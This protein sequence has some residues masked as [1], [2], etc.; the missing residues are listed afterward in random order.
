MPSRTPYAERVSQLLGSV[1]LGLALL[2][3]VIALGLEVFALAH[4][5][6]QRPDAFAAA[7]KSTKQRWVLGLVLAVALGIISLGPGLGL[8]TIIGVVIAGVYLAD[9]KPAIEEV[10]GRSR[11]QRGGRW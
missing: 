10:L 2:L 8:L 9:V 1:Q 4:A 3:S 11:G 6:R 5:A 7:G